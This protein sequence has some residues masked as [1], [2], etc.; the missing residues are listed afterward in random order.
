MPTTAKLA[1]PYPA[2]S[3]TPD[4]PYRMQLLAEAVETATPVKVRTGTGVAVGAVA[5][6][7]STTVSVTFPAGTFTT[8]PAVIAQVTS[9]R[10]GVATTAKSNTGFTITLS[11]W[12]S[13]ASVVGTMDWVAL[14]V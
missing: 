12:T 11:N 7:A 9:T 3:D 4:V 6:G 10:L 8:A 2:P 13:G 14:G 1:L 5:A